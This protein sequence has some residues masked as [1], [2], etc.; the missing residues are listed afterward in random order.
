M[1]RWL[2]KLSRFTSIAVVGTVAIGTMA[3]PTSSAVGPL[4]WWVAA[5]GP[6]ANTAT[7]GSSCANPSFAGSDHTPIQAAIT[8]AS[9]GDEIRICAGSYAVSSTLTV[10]KALTFT[11][12]GSQLP[13]L[14]GG[15]N[16][17]IM[18]ITTGGFAVT[19][20][21]L[22]FRNGRA[23]VTD[24][25]N[26]DFSGAGAGI[27]VH[28]NVTLN[29]NNSLFVSNVADKHG[30]GIAMLGSGSSTGS[31]H[32][33]TSTFY[34][35]RGL[36]GGGLAVAGIT[37][38]TSVVTNST[39]VNNSATRQG[40]A[41]NGSFAVLHGSNSTF[42]D[43]TAAEGGDTSWVVT[44]KGN[45]IAYTP[46]V[47]PSNNVCNLDGTTPVDNVSTSPSCLAGGESATTSSTLALG[48]LAPW[49]GNTPTFSVGI[50]SAAI[51]A[52]DPANCPSADQRGTSRGAT[53]CDAGAFEYQTNPP[54]LN[55]SGSIALVQGLALT[56]SPTFTKS[57]LDEPVT[58]RVASEI[59][60]SLPSG[61]S[62]SSTSG[63]FS[64]TPGS[65]FTTTSLVITATDTDGDVASASVP[66][67]N[68]VLDTTNG[69]YQVSNAI[70]LGLFQYGI[71][72]LNADY[73]QTADIEWNGVWQSAA[74]SATPFTG[75]YDGEG[76]SITGLQIAGGQTAFVPY[77][78]GATITN[79]DFDVALT[80]TYGSAALIRYATNTTID[81]VH[82][83]GSVTITGAE[84]CHGGLVGETDGSTIIKN[85]SFE[86]TV[87]APDSSWNGGLVGCT[88]GQTIIEKS[89]FDGTVTGI[90]DIGGL[91][92]WLEDS[93]IR[94]SYAT[95]TVTSS[96][97]SIGGLAGNVI[98]DG[99][100]ADTVAIVD[101]Y[102]STAVQGVAAIGALAGRASSTSIEA[103]FWEDGL[104]GVDGLF[105]VGE[106]TD[107]GGTQPAIAPTPSL[108][109][110]SFSFFR[111]ANWAIANGWSNPATN[112][113]VW[114][115]CDGQGR[116]FLL[117]QYST[118]PCVVAQQPNPPQNIVP[119]P[120][121]TPPS[122]T[123]PTPTPT[124][125]PAVSVGTT[126]VVVDGREVATTLTW[127]G[128]AVL[129]G[130]IDSVEFSLNLGSTATMTNTPRVGAGSAL[131][132]TMSGLKPGTAVDATLF[133]SPVKLGSFG[134]DATGRTNPSFAI[135]RGIESGSHR[136]RLDMTTVDGKQLSLWIG[137]GV[138]SA[139]PQ[140]PITGSGS[141]VLIMFA[142]WSAL[143]GLVLLHV[144]RRRSRV[145]LQL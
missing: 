49:G 27:R 33:A 131:T 30:G 136:L 108:S 63:E 6:A 135:P 28:P 105:P 45:L 84:G 34:K 111:D 92:G 12:V 66:V 51:G 4:V 43:N 88:Y 68:C 104:V 113:N 52:V 3:V 72:G 50:G 20:N 112:Q 114:G 48:I 53:P 2:S 24:Q 76:H 119:I 16:T 22:H 101:S 71:C 109:M 86:G 121:P 39:F 126:V 69:A 144:A 139:R 118:D 116:P 85:S 120:T 36:D 97:L 79:L 132:M 70:D 9:S 142:G 133:S 94:D 41:V 74:S 143:A 54:G 7:D 115:I 124:I 31:V 5:S 65:T 99:N 55:A 37:A 95:G 21:R 73:V 18:D 57:G 13:V 128:G 64:G 59:N 134:V 93:D 127:S 44:L 81:G 80:G 19:I 26:A 129:S 10:G 145:P 23:T 40:G 103:S 123:T 117:W 122:S 17:R 29:I 42:V 62:F 8:A 138:E 100:D 137:I 58:L 106:L 141:I 78:S 110:K 90:E 75:T 130:R 1:S 83:S 35:N 77:T 15:G 14:N 87:D 140:L 107:V 47:V 98:R 89:F 91:V 56:S 96:S 25:S 82:G 46:S 125:D 61:V 11:G 60:G 38:N 102:A 67:E 32:V